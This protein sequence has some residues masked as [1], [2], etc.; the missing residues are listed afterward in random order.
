MIYG[1]VIGVILMFLGV[2]WACVRA[3]SEY[4]RYMEQNGGGH[5]NG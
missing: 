5:D 3:G 1:I 2:G 4:D